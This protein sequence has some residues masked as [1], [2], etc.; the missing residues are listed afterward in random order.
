MQ[1]E[2]IS[3]KEWLA[4]TRAADVMARDVVTLN[5]SDPMAFAAQILLENEISGAP[6][7]ND[8]G[9]CVGVL[10]IRDV[11]D[12]E[13]SVAD[14]QQKLVSSSFWK[15]LLVLPPHVY[16]E[17]LEAVRDKLVPTSEQLVLQFM[18]SDLI[19]VRMNTPLCA[20]LEKIIFARVHRILVLGAAR[21]LKGIISNTDIL[22]A[23]QAAG[24]QA[25]YD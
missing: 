11:L 3:V 19:D 6:V 14:E 20:V 12:A 10:S 13:R 25:A 8:D 1:V 15:S 22:I 18:S 24:N 23:L 5:V 4:E 16:T 21:Q 9:Q 2:S 17:K 7:L